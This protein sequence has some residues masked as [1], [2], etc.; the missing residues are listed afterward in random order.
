[1]NAD[2]Q[3]ELA[4]LEARFDVDRERRDLGGTVEHKPEGDYYPAGE[5]RKDRTIKAQ[6]WIVARLRPIADAHRNERQSERNGG[7]KGGLTSGRNRIAKRGD[8]IEAHRADWERLRKTMKARSA[9]KIL[10][11]KTGFD[12]DSIARHFRTHPTA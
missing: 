8:C 1:M 11:R 5:R 4:T 7:R 9:A 3:Q 10:E 2:E 6:G 12:F